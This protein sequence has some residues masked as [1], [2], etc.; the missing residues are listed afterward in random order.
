M[1][2]NVGMGDRQLI[3]GQSW[4]GMATKDFVKV[5]GDGIIAYQTALG[6][7]QSPSCVIRDEP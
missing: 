5:I 7:S 3:D 4:N 2:E 6:W 1:P